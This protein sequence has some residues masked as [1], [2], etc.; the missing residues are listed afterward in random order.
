MTFTFK[1]I[2]SN[3]STKFEK[4]NNDELF[5]VYDNLYESG[6][7]IELYSNEKN[8]FIILSLDDCMPQ[9]TVYLTDVFKFT[10]PFD[11]HKASYNPKS[12]TGTRHYLYV[13]KATDLEIN[14]TRN[15]A[16]NPYDCH[17]N[18]TLFP[19]SYAN[20]ETRG[21]SVFASRN[22]IDGLVANTFHGEWPYS[23][24]GINRNPN[25]EFHLD[26]GRHICIQEIVFYLRA[27]FP[28]DSWWKQADVR[29]SDNTTMSFTFQKTGNA[30]HFKITDKTTTNVTLYNLLKAADDSPFPALTQI[31]VY[32][33][34]MQ[35]F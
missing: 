8:C 2:S 1:I 29:F 7:C 14:A 6:D 22:A 16:C 4:S 11:E 35:S 30:Q 25:A 24:W 23:S 20:V 19:H 10:I 9:A 15:L 26:F 27:D 21:E 3:G 17:E 18:S 13:R 34:E 31:E 33:T 5:A 12:F 32:G 28:H